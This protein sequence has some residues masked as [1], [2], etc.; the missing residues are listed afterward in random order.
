MPYRL[1]PI[2]ALALLLAGCD[3]SLFYGDLPSNDACREAE[4]LPSQPINSDC[5]DSL[6]R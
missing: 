1:L 6:G 3:I 2:V 4:S 5:L